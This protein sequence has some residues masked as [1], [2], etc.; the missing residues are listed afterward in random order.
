MRRV[1]S[2]CLPSFATDLLCRDRPEWRDRPLAT[3]TE[4]QAGP[5]LVAVNARAAAAGLR[6]GMSL[7]DAHA[8][9]PVFETV[10]ADPR[11]LEAA[12]ARLAAWCGRY[13]PW[14]TPDSGALPPGSSIPAGGQG[15]VWIDATG[16]AHLFAGEAALLADLVGRLA[17]GGFTARAA[18]ADTPG[19]AWAA[20]RF[21]TG[22]DRP[23]CIV[24]PDAA[25]RVLAP[26]PVAALRL[27][28]EAVAG[29]RRLGL[30]R[31]G[32]LLALPRAALGRRFGAAVM[33]RLDQA[34]GRA[35]EP[36][37]PHILPGRPFARLAF[38]EPIGRGADIA[39]ARTRLVAMLC[40]TL[41]RR[42]CGARRLVLGLHRVD[43]TM[44]H[45]AIGTSRASRAPAHLARLFD[46]HLE[47]VDPGFGIEVMVLGATSV[48]PLA[49]TQP[50]L[51]AGMDEAPEPGA[52]A[53][54]ID[55]LSNRLGAGRVRRIALRES[56]IPE[57][58]V[59]MPPAIEGSTGTLPCPSQSAMA[60]PAMARPAVARP[61]RLLL[62]PEPIEATAP[63]PDEPPLRF[64]WRRVHYR[65]RRAEGPE[66]IA[67]EWWCAA[68]P[69]P[70]DEA[71]EDETTRD[72]YRVEVTGGRRFWVFRRGLYRPGAHP[73]WFL[74]G[75][76]E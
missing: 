71:P 28:A 68:P 62:R 7:A 22:A 63:V 57:R 33:T 8:L 26:L 74:H 41:A 9:L 67:P 32:D 72:Y 44:Q 40:A 20:C 34:L 21:A 11:T 14:T 53:A 4:A 3:L 58:A 2:L 69:P 56:H 61:L 60:R 27:E 36:L 73:V 66:R 43:A 39:A 19:A 46:E 52:A 1:I 76:F 16:C 54:L 48:E 17:Q 13:S 15:S 47:T 23:W 49:A 59:T 75:I 18:I 10:A 29:L 12:C 35:A 45:L 42:Q 51:D 24:A 50:D 37:S 65:V 55:R 6:P 70:A 64:R 30:R 38:A 5:L 25:C 31:I